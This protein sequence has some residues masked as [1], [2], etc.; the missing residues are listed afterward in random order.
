MTEPA[1]PLFRREAVA[2]AAAP[3]RYD[4]ALSV[5]RPWTWAAGGALL[6]M[7][8][9]GLVW[10]A[11]VDVPV[12][13]PGRGILL[14]PG[15][16]VDIVA[17]TDGRLDRILARPGER[18]E[19]GRPVAVVDQSEVRLHSRWPRARR[20]DAARQLA[21]CAP[22]SAGGGGGRR[23]PRRRDAAL[24]QNLRLLQERLAMMQEREEVLR[25]SA[26]RTSVN[27]DRFL[28]SRVEVF[29]VREQMRRPETSAAARA[30]PAAEAHPAGA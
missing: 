2:E 26:S 13:V 7:A 30:R 19:A 8:V 9:I 22:S 25:G 23:L 10:A 24:V 14:P 3:D 5:M 27:R 11:L 18:V 6:A 1:G 4:E 29:Q 16:V 17:D 20:T 15:G 28:F 21:S 12:K